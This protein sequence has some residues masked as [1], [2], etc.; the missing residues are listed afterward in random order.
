MLLRDLLLVCLYVCIQ[1]YHPLISSSLTSQYT[2]THTHTHT[3]PHTQT[4]PETSTELLFDI[5]PNLFY[6]AYGRNV[7]LCSE[8]PRKEYSM[9]SKHKF[10]QN[11]S[12][13]LFCLRGLKPPLLKSAQ[14]PW[15][16]Q[17]NQPLKWDEYWEGGCEIPIFSRRFSTSILCVLFSLLLLL[18][19]LLSLLLLLLLSSSIITTIEY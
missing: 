17:L 7:R 11:I 13:C 8:L 5:R 1:I 2:H 10:T 4:L 15:K 16:Y 19:L 14:V 18:L 6:E 9:S 12:V 3:H